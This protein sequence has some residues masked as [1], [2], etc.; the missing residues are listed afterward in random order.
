MVDYPQTCP[1]PLAH[2]TSPPAMEPAAVS[3]SQAAL[4]TCSEQPN[5]AEITRI[6][7]GTWA[8]AGLAAGRHVSQAG[9]PK[10]EGP[11]RQRKAQFGPSCSSH[12]GEAWDTVVKP[13]WTSELRA[14]WVAPANNAWSRNAEVRAQPTHRSVRNS[15]SVLHHVRQFR[16]DFERQPQRMENKFFIAVFDILEMINHLL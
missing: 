6:H 5:A 14:E 15:K 1:S 16:G 7:F 10:G 2:A 12:P 4:V 9:L 3:F 11:R 8:S 13:S